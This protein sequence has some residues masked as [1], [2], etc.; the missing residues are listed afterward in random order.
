MINL[1]WFSTLQAPTPQDAQGGRKRTVAWNG[2]K[3]S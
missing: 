2:L 1:A 3:M